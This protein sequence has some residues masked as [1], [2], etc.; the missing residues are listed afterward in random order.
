MLLNNDHLIGILFHTILT[1]ANLFVHNELICQWTTCDFGFPVSFVFGFLFNL[2][3][4]VF[5]A[6]FMLIVYCVFK[7]KPFS[8]QSWNSLCNISYVNFKRRFI[9]WLITHK[10]GFLSCYKVYYVQASYCFSVSFCY[11]WIF[12]CYAHQHQSNALNWRKVRWL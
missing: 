12:F 7:F 11:S 6:I 3:S 5:T 1:C 10:M 4:Y 9:P 2:L 8:N